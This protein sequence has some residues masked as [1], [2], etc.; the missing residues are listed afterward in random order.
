MFALAEVIT[1]KQ[2]KKNFN[3]F[4]E[5]LFCDY[6]IFKQ[7]AEQFQGFLIGSQKKFFSRNFGLQGFRVIKSFRRD[8]KMRFR[9][10]FTFY[11]FI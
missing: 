7:T 8:S 11:K 2:Q 10:L 5:L 9:K 1:A 3:E 6:E 4:R